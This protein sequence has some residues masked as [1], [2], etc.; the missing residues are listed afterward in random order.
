MKSTEWVSLDFDQTLKQK[1][2][3]QSEPE[4]R[5]VYKFGAIFIVE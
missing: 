3:K 4:K 1:I 5:F 2:K